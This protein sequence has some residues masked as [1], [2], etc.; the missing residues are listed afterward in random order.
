VN[1]APVVFSTIESMREFVAQQRSQGL[2]IGL[3]PTMGALHAGHLS[4]AQASED[5]CDCT[6]VTIFVNPSQFAPGEDFEAY[7]RTLESD[8]KQLATLNVAAVFAPQAA[9]IYPENFTT[10]IL[11]PQ[12]SQPLEGIFRPDHYAGVCEVVLKLFN[13]VQADVAYF[14]QKDYQQAAVLQAMVVDLNVPIE[15]EVCPIV[16]EDDGLAM[17]SRNIYLSSEERQQA[18]TLSRSLKLAGEL[19]DAGET[20]PKIVLEAMYKEFVA[21]NIDSIDYIELVDPTTLLPVSSLQEPTIALI[22][23]HIGETRLIDN[24][25]L[26]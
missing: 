9:E 19:V 24:S 4:L 17:S 26:K 8:L 5:H 22:A 25:V 6:I 7:P 20:N 1:T 14:G 13:L 10:R 21:A 23:C 16:R 12:V 15:I 11:P 3:V 2:R 18:L